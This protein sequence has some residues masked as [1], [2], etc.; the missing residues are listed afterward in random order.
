M[1]QILLI[2]SSLRNVL[3]RASASGQFRSWRKSGSSN[4]CSYCLVQGHTIWGAIYAYHGRV[5]ISQGT[6]SIGWQMS[7]LVFIL[8]LVSLVISGCAMTAGNSGKPLLVN[9]SS[10]DFGS[11][12]VGGSSWQ[13]ATIKNTRSTKL[14]V[15]QASVKGASFSIDSLSLP[16]TLSPGQSSSLSVRFAPAVAGN[17]TGSVSLVSKASGSPTVI[18]LTGNGFKSLSTPA[19]ISGIATSNITGSGAMISWTTDKPSTSQV[20]WGT[21]ASYGNSSQLDSSMVTSHAV[22]VGGLNADTLYHFRVKS[23]DDAGSLVV[24]SDSTFAIF[25]AHNSSVAPSTSPQTISRVVSSNI[26]PLNSIQASLFGMTHSDK[27]SWPAVS[28]GA[29]GKGTEVNWSYSEP[30]KGVFNW[31]NLDAWVQSASDHGVDFFFS[32]DRIPPWAAADQST[33]AP[34]FPGSKVLGCTSMVANIQDW[35][36]FV[37]ALVTRYKG[38][39]RIYELWNEPNEVANFSG[40]VADMVTLAQHMIA[41]V[42]SLD[43]AALVVGPGPSQVSPSSTWLNS[44]FTAG[45]PTSIDAVTLHGYPH[46]ANDVPESIQEFADEAKAIMAK[47][48][49]TGKPVWDTEGSWGDTSDPRIINSPDQQEAFVARNYLL[50]WS[51]GV[52]RFYWYAWDGGTW[53]VLWDPV[54]GAHQAAKAY[55]Q[56][57]NWMVGATMNPPCSMAVD[58]TWTCGLTRPGGYAAQAVWNSSGAKSYLAPSQYTQYRDLNGSTMPIPPDHSVTIGI[59]PILLESKAAASPAGP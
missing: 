47:Y 46:I 51:N 20:E 14:T 53:G 13:N 26:T 12:I 19:M 54:N 50:H 55:Q 31:A 44:Y 48:G 34:T 15:T 6:R 9:P 8:S 41:K 57:Y 40:S 18:A 3:P 23:Q 2:N 30:Q 17:L 25:G 45:G 43:P 39:I 11:V 4:S 29:L 32:N 21:S 24:S 42:R 59:K 16:L 49:L 27:A 22:T 52:T 38:K 58:S 37:T 7:L 36:D 5:T 28:V 10:L 56:V 35:D 1:L 33:C